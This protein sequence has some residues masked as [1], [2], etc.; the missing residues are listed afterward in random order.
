M[1]YTFDKSF[2]SVYTL[3]YH[4]IICIKYRRKVFG[5]DTIINELKE[6]TRNIAKRFDITIINQE[7]DKDHTHILFSTKPSSNLVKFINS[8]KGATAK[9]IRHRYPEV[10][11]YLWRDVF[12]SSSY[13][14]ITTGQVTLDQLK[15]YVEEQGG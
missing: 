6:R 8:L 7:C 5:N 9:A 1:K 11:K 3:N 2:H 15:K 12:W 14:L 4:L 10:K 13:C